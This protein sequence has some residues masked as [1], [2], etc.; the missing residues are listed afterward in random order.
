MPDFFES[1]FSKPGHIIS[2]G[3]RLPKAKQEKILWHK[4]GAI[5]P[6]PNLMPGKWQKSNLL[7]PDNI[8]KLPVKIM[9]S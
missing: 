4:G 7:P 8:A 9:Q 6:D 3:Q 1:D 5:D 2:V